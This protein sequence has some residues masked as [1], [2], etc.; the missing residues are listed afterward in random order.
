[1]SYYINRTIDKDFKETIAAVTEALKKEG[2]GV[3]TQVN[4][5]E[6]LK[7]KL[8]VNFRNYV[9]LGACNPSLAH[10]ALQLE[11]KIGVMLPCNIVIQEWAPGQ[12][13]IAAIDPTA[14]M[15]AVDNMALDAIASEVSDKLKKVVNSI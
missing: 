15:E 2:F 12:V 11:D 3:L 1:M 13:E 6:K 4:M 8:N 5:A 14:S 7:E 10:K 9:I